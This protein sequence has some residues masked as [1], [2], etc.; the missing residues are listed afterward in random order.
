MELKENEN[1]SIYIQI[2]DDNI[3]IP[4]YLNGEKYLLNIYPSKDNINIIFKL[5]KENIQTYYFFAKFDLKDFK[6]IS[7]IFI[8]YIN[9]QGIFSHLINICKIYIINLEL[10]KKEFKIII[11]FQN[12]GKKKIKF[13]LIKKIVSQEKINP[14]LIGRIIDN[15]L[16]LKI[17]NNQIETINKSL[18]IKED[19][20]KN[21]NTNITNINDTLNNVLNNIPIY[22][23]TISANNNNSV[24]S[25][26]NST[27]IESNSYSENNSCNNSVNNIEDEYQEE[28]N[29]EKD[30]KKDF[31]N[32]INNNNNNNNPN[33]L[34]CY[35]TSQNK[36]I[37]EFLIILNVVTILIVLYILGSNYNPSINL[38]FNTL[39]NEDYGNRLAYLSMVN[40]PRNN[41]NFRD[42]FQENLDLQKSK[43]DGI[44]NSKIKD[45]YI[46]NKK[47]KTQERIYNNYYDYI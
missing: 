17:F 41:E 10:T 22:N 2:T 30:D 36:K 28:T 32:N 14:V 34:F 13:T 7:K 27:S 39:D 45:E 31:N 25:T 46:E 21:I 37:M 26:K 18:N 19:T 12:E 23:T 38:E 4:I 44:T 16:K 29:K 11:S 43:E 5:T 3:K 33:A 6:K 35:D 24:V 15:K 1:E 8:N 9:I 42:I 40:N 47:K 20:I